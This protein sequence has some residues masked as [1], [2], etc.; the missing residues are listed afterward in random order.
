VWPAIALGGLTSAA[1]WG[2]WAA[3]HPQAQA[4]GRGFHSGPA[5]GSLLALTFDDGP[6]Q[7]TEPI[8]DLLAEHGVH[9]T[10]FVCGRNVERSPHI[11]RRALAEGHEIANH[12]HN[13]PLLLRL[14][15]AE[16]R[17]EVVRAQ[18]AIEDRLGVAPAMFRAPYGIRALGLRR[19]LEDL[20]LT[21]VHWTV[22]GNDWKW[23]AERI[24]RRVLTR[25]APGAIVCLHDGR[26]ARAHADRSQTIA[27]VQIIAPQLAAAGYHFVTASQMHAA[28]DPA[29]SYIIGAK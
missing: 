8:L 11:S 20:G 5:A 27:A 14:G 25:A 24:A 29:R 10:F 1:A 18:R 26:E 9:A 13:H 17:R 28:F 3:A 16:V 2:A 4:W 15:P 21:H 7:A 23:S 12:S 6:N 22:I 19:T